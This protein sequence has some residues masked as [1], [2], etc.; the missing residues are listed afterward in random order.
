M[1]CFQRTDY[2]HCKNT[3]TDYLRYLPFRGGDDCPSPGEWARL[4]LALRE[5]SGSDC[6]TLAS[7]S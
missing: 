3:F 2:G 6:G 1:F 5:E 4:R 7:R